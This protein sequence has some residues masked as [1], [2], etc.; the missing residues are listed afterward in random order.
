MGVS[1]ICSSP[2]SIPWCFRP[3]LEEKHLNSSNCDLASTSGL[4]VILLCVVVRTS[5]VLCCCTQ[6][7]TFVFLAR[8]CPICSSNHG[9]CF[10]TCGRTRCADVG[11]YR[12]FRILDLLLLHNL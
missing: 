2:D 5:N 4:T 6:I 12:F 11:M 9:R 7:R 8:D 10:S 3:S 1:G